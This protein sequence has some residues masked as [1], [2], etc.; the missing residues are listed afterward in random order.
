MLRHPARTQSCLCAPLARLCR[1]LSPSVPVV[2]RVGR[3]PQHGFVTGA[4]LRT[5]S[6]SD[7]RLGG[8][9]L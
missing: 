5:Q 8:V 1:L 3:E 7:N 2:I 6:L 9:A 4:C